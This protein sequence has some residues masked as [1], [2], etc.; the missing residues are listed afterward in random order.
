MSDN[1]VEIWMPLYIGDTLKEMQGMTATEI[2]G[3]ILLLMSAWSN[4]GYLRNDIAYLRTLSKLSDKKLDNALVH[5]KHAG[6]RI[7][8]PRLQK[9]YE[10]A[11]VMRKK[12]S[13]QTAAAREAKL[14][15]KS[16]VTETVTAAVTETTSPPPSSSS[17]SSS[18]AVS[19][20]AHV[21]GAGEVQAGSKVSSEDWQG[22][23]KT[24]ENF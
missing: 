15:V 22:L 23:W 21:G 5:F 13:A 16:S 4:G 2:G 9:L 20:K 12:K 19:G 11:V 10:E 6:G 7:Y 14:Q 24:V 1:N 3:Y 17:T 8:H 18:V